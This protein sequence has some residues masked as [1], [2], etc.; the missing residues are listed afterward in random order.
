MNDHPLGGV[1]ERHSPPGLNSVDTS[2]YTHF[3]PFHEPASFFFILS[4]AHVG[5]ACV[6]P[7][8]YVNR[9]VQARG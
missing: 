4:L 7:C 9:C 5:R 1:H 3:Y 2:H 8:G 6:H